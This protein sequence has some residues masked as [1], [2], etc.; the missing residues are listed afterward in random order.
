MMLFYTIIAP[1]MLFI[2]ISIIML[3]IYE[4]REDSRK[5]IMEFHLIVYTYVYVTINYYSFTLIHSPTV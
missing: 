4:L 3:S 1:E 2:E 5:P